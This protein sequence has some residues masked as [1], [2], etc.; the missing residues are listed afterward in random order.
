MGK[1]VS[2]VSVFKLVVLVLSHLG[3]FVMDA[4]R[5]EEVKKTYDAPAVL[6]IGPMSSSL[7]GRRVAGPL[8]GGGP[9]MI[10]MYN[11]NLQT[12]P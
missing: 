7:H 10:G 6:T 4:V 2:L 1:L 3:G 8:D 9:A 11:L 5:V 12:A